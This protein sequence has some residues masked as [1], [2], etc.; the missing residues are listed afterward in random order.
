MTDT[1]KSVYDIITDRF[2]EQLKKGII[3]WEKPWLSLEGERVG[4][5]GHDKK[6]GGKPYS[7]LNQMMLPKTGEY[8]TF[9]QVKAEGGTIKK[10]AKGYPITFWKTWETEVRNPK[11]NQ[12]EIKSV[13]V[14]R[15]YTVFHI[16]DTEGIE[17]NYQPDTSKLDGLTEPQR[18]KKADAIVKSYLEMTGVKLV[19]E[20]QDRAFY[21]FVQD[22]VTLPLKKQFGK[23]AEY[24]S[25]LFHELTHSTGHRDR[26]NRLFVTTHRRGT[27]YSLE[28]LVAEI[29]ACAMMFNLG[30]ETKD[31]IMNSNAYLE[32]WYAALRNDPKMIVKASGRAQKAVRYLYGDTSVLPAKVV[33]Y[34]EKIEAVVIDEINDEDVPF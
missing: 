10:G 27:D 7:L 15:Y 29:G 19:H 26:L 23:K 25:T 17:Q 32:S 2:T 20:A 22:Q 14:L 12:M 30:L 1:K 24:Y 3:P 28:E 4:A 16:S 33:K 21:N 6:N 11:T 8:V 31:S 9:K 18:S 5:W 13:P 34:E